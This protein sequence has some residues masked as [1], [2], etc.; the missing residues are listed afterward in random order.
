M[1]GKPIDD[2]VKNLFKVLCEIM[3]MPLKTRGRNPLPDDLLYESLD[4][5]NF[6]LLDSDL[7]LLNQLACIKGLCNRKTFS[8]TK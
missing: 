5:I 3:G 1:Q 6:S 4:T 7:I 2:I 8:L